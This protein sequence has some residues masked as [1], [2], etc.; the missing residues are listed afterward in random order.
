MSATEH[1]EAPP[2][3]FRT[4]LILW[5]TQSLSAF[6][7]ALTFFAITIWLAQTLYPREEQKPQLAFALT[8]ISLAFAL[9][10]LLA[11]VAG[12]WVDRHDRKRTMLVVDVANAF[13]SLLLM[14]LMIAKALEVW[15]VVILVAGFA[16]LSQFHSAAFDTSYAMIVPEKQLPRANGMMQTMWALSGILSP[17]IA[18]TLIALPELARQGLVPGGL[19]EMLAP[20]QDGAPLAIGIDAATFLV[21]AAIL[22]FL[23]IPSPKRTDL[24]TD[25]AG[26]VKKK[27]MWADIK[28]GARYIKHRPP[29]LWLLAT[30]TV[31]NFAASPV[32]IF[33]PLLLKF[34][35]V[36][37]WT[38]LGLTFESAFALVATLGGIGGV[39][40]GVIMSAWGGLKGRKV[41]GVVVPILIAGVMQIVF[42]LSSF[43]YLTAAMNFLLIGLLPIMNSHS[44]TI[45]QTQVP[46]ELQGRVF[47]VRRVIAQFSAPLGVTLA[48]LAGGLLDPGIVLVALGALVVVFCI[49]QL[50]NPY[51]LRVEDKEW[52]EGLAA[53]A[54]R[55]Q[56]DK[57]DKANQVA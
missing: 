21:A 42:G 24:G 27:S 31:V 6:G 56:D 48:G 44:Q 3:G 33:I 4:F 53:Q 7:S 47:S 43:V 51:L 37:D 32:G 14:S 45:W 20:L 30:F 49:G 19:G 35:L 54:Q 52:V 18:A 8:A 36:G 29:L 1:Y 9:S 22:P 10:V 5:V 16:I 34:K 15:M 26:V 23:R 12:A 28:E 11:P 57:R 55:A 40:G 2:N 41:Y 38:S 25:A 13:L 17:A 50:F 46:R 39:I